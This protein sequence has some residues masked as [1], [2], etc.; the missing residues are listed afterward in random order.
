MSPN[1][2]EAVNG[3]GCHSPYFQRCV[4]V[5]FQIRVIGVFG[6][7]A[8]G[9]FVFHQT[10]DCQFTIDGCD[11]NAAVARFE[12][13][14][15]NEDVIVIDSGTNHRVAGHPYKKGGSLIFNQ[16][17]IEVKFLVKVVIRRGGEA[18]RNSGKKERS[19]EGSSVVSRKYFPDRGSVFYV[20][21][22]IHYFGVI[23]AVQGWDT[24]Q[25]A[26]LR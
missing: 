24:R 2:S 26:V 1:I 8:A 21:M 22:F 23:Q 10:L 5:N 18:C 9:V 20:Q 16:M 19:P 13:A 11:D 25:L 6:S 7:Q 17:F 14:V 3:I 12:G 15:N 4:L